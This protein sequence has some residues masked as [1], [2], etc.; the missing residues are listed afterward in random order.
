MVFPFPTS[1]GTLDVEKLNQVNALIGGY[2]KT[3]Y[4][5]F[6]NAEHAGPGIGTNQSCTACHNSGTTS[7]NLKF[8]SRGPLANLTSATQLFAKMS[9]K[10]SFSMPT[11]PFYQKDLK[12]FTDAMAKANLLP[13]ADRKKIYEM[14]KAFPSKST[15][16]GD[17]ELYVLPDPEYEKAATATVN[18]WSQNDIAID[19]AVLN[20]LTKRGLITASERDSAET[21]LHRFDRSSKSLFVAMSKDYANEFITWLHGG[22][23]DCMVSA[24]PNE[25]QTQTVK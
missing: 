14:A 24:G 17:R 12:P 13:D 2:K 6:F 19:V 20:A 9:V 22:T 8:P 11:L 21:A 25:S 15:L 1:V 18:S 23:R 10:G 16:D 5:P 4:A 3:G 7:D